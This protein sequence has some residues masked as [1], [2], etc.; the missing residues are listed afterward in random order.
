MLFLN[1]PFL[2][3]FACRTD[4]NARINGI[5]ITI[6]VTNKFNTLTQSL[7]LRMSEEP[8]SLLVE[9][10]TSSCTRAPSH[11]ITRPQHWLLRGQMMHD[12]IANIKDIAVICAFKEISLVRA[13]MR[14][15]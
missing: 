5:V 4:M 1:F 9:L 7:I 3:R 15:L 6:F 12:A 11:Y 8:L 2:F 13:R 10:L 14:K